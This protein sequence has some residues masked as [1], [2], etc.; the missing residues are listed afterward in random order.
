M[1]SAGTTFQTIFIFPPFFPALLHARPVIKTRGA[2]I[3]IFYFNS[4]GR[5]REERR[6]DVREG[7]G[8]LAF[9][10]RGGWWGGGS[11]SA[12]V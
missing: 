11:G 9:F 1:A 4:R 10:F 6:G 8:I 12:K 5:K 2:K 3:P 7:K